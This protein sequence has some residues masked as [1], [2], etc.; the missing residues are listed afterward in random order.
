MRTYF[1]GTIFL[2]LI[3]GFAVCEEAEVTI[4]KDY[5]IN[6]NWDEVDNAFQVIRLKFKNGSDS[7]N[8]KNT[9][10]SELEDKLEEDTSF[11]YVANVKY[12]GVK[13]SERRVYFNR[14][15]GFLWRKPP[16]IDPSRMTTYKTIGELQQD[17]WYLLAGLSSFKTFYYVYIDSLD[18]LHRFAII[19]NN[20]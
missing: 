1:V 19:V 18:N 17:T 15:N 11:S 9:W 2:L 20:L 14:D 7:I 5:V 12:N 4:T 10:Q 6:P 3:L 8:Y 13:Y 16:D